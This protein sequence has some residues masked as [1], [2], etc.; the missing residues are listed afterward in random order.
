MRAI[1]GVAL[2]SMTDH[3]LDVAHGE[4]FA[5]GDGNGDG[6]RQRLRPVER[7]ETIIEQDRVCVHGNSRIR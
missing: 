4:K 1:G 7:V 5:I 6:G 2:A 3:I